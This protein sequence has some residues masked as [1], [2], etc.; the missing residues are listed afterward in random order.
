MSNFEKNLEQAL[1]N[2][3]RLTDKI[4]IDCKISHFFYKRF[5][6]HFNR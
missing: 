2:A 6:E 1:N 3:K 4:L 5:V